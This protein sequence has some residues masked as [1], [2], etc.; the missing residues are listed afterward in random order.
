MTSGAS[1]AGVVARVATGLVLGSFGVW[2]LTAP[3]EWTGYVPT[4]AALP[5][6]L[7]PIV[8][9]HGWILFMLAVAA[10]IN[11]L[12]KVTAWLSVATL[13]LVCAGLVW[14]SGVTSIFVRDIGLLALALIWAGEE[15]GLP[16]Y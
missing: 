4:L 1:V 3:S 5:V 16:L 10:W 15:T 14:R 13:V 12:P 9:A 8:L 7:V 2:E 11:F 6:P